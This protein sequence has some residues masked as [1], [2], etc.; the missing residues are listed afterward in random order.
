MGPK[1]IMYLVTRTLNSLAGQQVAHLV[2]GDGH[3]DADRHEDDAE[4]KEENGAH[5]GICYFLG[6]VGY[7]GTSHGQ[8]FV[9]P[10]ACPLF[11][12]Q[13]GLHRQPGGS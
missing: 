12:I 4:D 13:H 9:G 7:L 2:Q 3:G 8:T 11:S 6:M 10:R 5:A 1:P